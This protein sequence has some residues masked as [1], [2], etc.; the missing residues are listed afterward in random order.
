LIERF[1]LARLDDGPVPTPAIE[2]AFT[3]LQ[4]SGGRARIG[5]LAG[6]VG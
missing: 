3:V 4:A 2:R 6:E 5:A 1:L